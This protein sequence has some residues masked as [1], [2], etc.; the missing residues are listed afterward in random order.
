M[1][2]PF[3]PHYYDSHVHKGMRRV[4][5]WFLPAFT[6]QPFDENAVADYVSV[7]GDIERGLTPCPQG[8]LH[9]DFHFE[10]LMFI[11]DG[12]NARQKTGLLDF[13]GA[14]IG[15]LVYDLVNLL[16]DARVSV[17]QE[18]QREMIDLYCASMSAAEKAL[19]MAWYRILGTQFHCRVIGQFVKLA[20]ESGKIYYLEHIPRLQ[21]YI[22]SA[23]DDPILA[24]LKAWFARYDIDF[25]QDFAYDPKQIKAHVAKDAF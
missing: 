1:V 2:M 21:S 12:E 23:L 17:P 4:V 7:W 10:N 14:M 11:A 24:P 13:Q 6:H 8:L 20:S 22:A 19:F 9:I 3:V 18:I 5:E 25:S 15:P 16:E